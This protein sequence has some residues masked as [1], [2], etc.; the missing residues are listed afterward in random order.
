MNN[1]LMVTYGYWVTESRRS[2]PDGKDA[3]GKEVWKRTFTPRIPHGRD[4]LIRP[5]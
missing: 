3:A 2:S 1:E 4:L 5:F